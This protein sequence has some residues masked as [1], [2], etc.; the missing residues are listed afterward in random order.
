MIFTKYNG[1]EEI[2]IRNPMVINNTIVNC[3][4]IIL[5]KSMKDSK[6]HFFDLDKNREGII[7]K[8]LAK[9]TTLYL[10]NTGIFYY[11]N[12]DKGILWTN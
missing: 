3:N 8:S 6:L 5:Y 2:V 10:T 9:M 1:K 11:D 4:N 7:N 12:Q